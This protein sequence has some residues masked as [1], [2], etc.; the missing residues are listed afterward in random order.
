MDGP[1]NYYKRELSLSR[2]FSNDRCMI[3]LVKIIYS[4]ESTIFK[5]EISWFLSSKSPSFINLFSHQSKL[6]VLVFGNK[7]SKF[8]L[9]KMGEMVMKTMPI[10]RRVAIICKNSQVTWQGTS[11][12]NLHGIP[13]LSLSNVRLVKEG[14][15]GRRPVHFKG[16]LQQWGCFSNHTTKSSSLIK[17]KLRKMT[18][19]PCWCLWNPISHP[20]VSNELYY[21]CGYNQKDMFRI[22]LM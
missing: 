13:F 21:M 7:Y 1:C 9:Y 12:P 14:K 6:I 20:R 18:W 5:Y 4:L 10:W 17:G 11:G 16:R 22:K 3:S 2:N 8:W 19:D 15:Q